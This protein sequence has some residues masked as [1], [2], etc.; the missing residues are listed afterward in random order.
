MV[1]EGSFYTNLLSVK[2]N[3]AMRSDLDKI[4]MFEHR[5]LSE[6]I[7]EWLGDKTE[8]YSKRPDYKHF[9]KQLET[10]N[11]KRSKI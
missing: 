4:A 9:L 8:G 2:L 11:E 1:S 5:K 7:R 10:Q 6:L 3:P